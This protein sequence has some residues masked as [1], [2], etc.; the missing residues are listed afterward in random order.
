MSNEIETP[1]EKLIRAAA[2]QANQKNETKKRKPHKDL[3]EYQKVK[4]YSL[5][6]IDKKCNLHVS[7]NQYSYDIVQN[8][9]VELPKAIIDFLKSATMIVHTQE[10]GL[11][12]T[13]FEPQYAVTT[14]D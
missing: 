14:V 5:N 11:P 7:I 1:E 12:K 13:E 8:K 10:G 4:V 6:T 2:E 9:A 3:G